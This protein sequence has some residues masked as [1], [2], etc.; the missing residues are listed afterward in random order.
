MRTKRTKR[1]LSL[2][3]RV[4]FGVGIL[5]GFLITLTGA[6]PAY[7]LALH[8]ATEDYT[9]YLPLV[10]KEYPFIPDAPVLDPISNQDGDGTFTVSW[11]LSEGA[12]SYTLQEAANIDFS[13]ASTVYS[14]PD[15]SITISGRAIGTYFYRV[16]AATSDTTSEWS[17]IQQVIVTPPMSEVYVENGTGSQLCY[18]VENTGIGQ[19]CFPIGT[20]Y[21][22][23]FPSGSYTYRASASCGTDSGTI[24]FE[25]GI[26]T[27][28]FWCE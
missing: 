18:T 14:G 19:K 2:F 10:V 17:N 16:R 15:T 20:H 5:A 13:N 12:T 7:G 4:L 27:H 26:F 9:L 25:P 6:A 3:V 22:G 24:Y 23:T 21:Y 28:R 11:S 8:N 1:F